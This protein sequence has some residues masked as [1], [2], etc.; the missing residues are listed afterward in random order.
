MDIESI[1]AH[2]A[3]P[4]VR[5]AWLRAGQMES[6]GFVG[7]EIREG[8][9]LRALFKRGRTFHDCVLFEPTADSRHGAGQPGEPGSLI[10][11][12]TPFQVESEWGP[13]AVVDRVLPERFEDPSNWVN[14]AIQSIL[15]NGVAEWPSLMNDL[16]FWALIGHLE[17]TVTDESLARLS[18]ALESLPYG[19]IQMFHNM[20]HQKLFELDQPGNTVRLGEGEAAI[21]SSDA[22]LYYRCEIVA[23]G[24][25]AFERH[26]SQPMH[27]SENAGAVGEALLG[28]AEDA[29]DKPLLDPEIPIE[30]GSNPDHW[31]VAEA[32]APISP[33]PGPFS[34]LIQQSRLR[35]APPTRL[36]LVGFAAYAIAG[37][38]IRE[39]LGCVMAR[40]SLEARWEVTPFLEA[41]VANDW[42]LHPSIHIYT[43]GSAGVSTG[44]SM[45]QIDRKSSQNLDGFAEEWHLSP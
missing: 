19:Q 34:Y 44:W 20:F 45:V 38:Q 36:G 32:T 6:Q 15:P 10:L 11:S 16:E 2:D 1:P 9:A 7:G 22:S 12:I 35:L 18:A 42:T 41:R 21:V 13:V 43:T 24:P 4:G 27:G 28:I 29:A 3:P 40:N 37:D 23:A 17:G 14:T 25:R 33:S 5:E 31:D 8:W 26:L 39:I 30:T